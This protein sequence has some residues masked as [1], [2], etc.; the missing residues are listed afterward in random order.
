MCVWMNKL[1]YRMKDHGMGHTSTKVSGGVNAA[2]KET[3]FV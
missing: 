2:T 3:P 1:A